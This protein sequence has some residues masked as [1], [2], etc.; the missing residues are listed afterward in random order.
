MLKTLQSW[1]T[2]LLIFALAILGALVTAGFLASQRQPSSTPVMRG[3]YLAQE[4]G[5]FACH[6]PGGV[7]GAS[8]PGAL[9]GAT[10]PFKAGGPIM[11]FVQSD[12][13]I[14]EWILY[15]APRRLWKNGNKP[16]ERRNGNNSRNENNNS[17][18]KGRDEDDSGWDNTQGV[19]GLIQMPAFAG[20]LSENELNDLV[21]YVKTIMDTPK[22]RPPLAERGRRI[23]AD[24]GCFGCHGQGGRGGVSNPGS[25]KGYIPPWDGTDFAELVENEEELRQWILEGKVDRFEENPLA[26]YFTHGQAIQMPA[27][28]DVLQDG[29]LEAIIAYIDWLRSDDK[30]FFPYWIEES[31]PILPSVVERGKWLFHKSGCVAC[32]GPKGVG[33]VPNKNAAGGFVPALD[34]LAE[35]MELFEKEDVDTIVALFEQGLSLEDPSIS[36]PV[37][38]FDAVLTQ[39]LNFRKLILKGGYPRKKGKKEASPAM[40]MPSWK[41]R[42]YANGAPASRSD[43]NAIIA[44]LLTL[45]EI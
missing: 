31:V 14:R 41:N 20:L 32:H 38:Y 30:Q 17:S 2:L 3:Y 35:K 21:S 4:M 15:G 40:V 19:G 9:W 12:E 8:N 11:S 16:S 34:D 23:A 42:L 1:Q 44:Y 43:I 22:P 36:E 33:G 28:E 10:P 18:G 13:E 45:Q 37:T 29:E 7:I 27:F 24:M 39:Y 5:C 26:T 6:G 25:F